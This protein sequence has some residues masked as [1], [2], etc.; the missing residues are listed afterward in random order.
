MGTFTFMSATDSWGAQIIRIF[1]GDWIDCR[2]S[3]A[4]SSFVVLC[5]GLNIAESEV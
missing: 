5:N 4:C 2:D 3:S 1:R